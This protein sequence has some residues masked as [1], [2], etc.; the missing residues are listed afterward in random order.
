MNLRLLALPLLAVMTGCGGSDSSTAPGGPPVGV[1]SPTPS[2]TPTS[3]A[4]PNILLIVTDDLNT[5]VEGLDGHP[6]AYTP[7][8][9]RLAAR[10]VLFT[11]AQANGTVCSPSRASLLSG[12]LPSTTGKHFANLDFLDIPILS[13][14]KLLPEHFRDEGYAVYGT[15]KIFHERHNVV[16]GTEDRATHPRSRTDTSGGYLGPVDSYGPYPWDGI[17]KEVNWPSRTIP[18]GVAGRDWAPNSNDTVNLLAGGRW[19]NNPALPAAVQDWGFGFGRLSQPPVFRT[20]MNST[21]PAGWNYAGWSEYVRGPYSWGQG[22]RQPISD[23]QMTNWVVSLLRRQ[24]QADPRYINTAPISQRPFMIMMGLVGTHAPNYVPD[25]FFDKVITVNKINSID[26][27][28]LP[29]SLGG[30]LTGDGL[31][32]VPRGLYPYY[33]SRQFQTILTGG[34]EGG[35]I[36]DLVHPGQSITNTPARLIK[37]MILAYLA[38]VYEVDVQLGKILDALDADPSLAR[39]T[40]VVLTSDHGFHL[41]EKQSWEKG[42]LFNGT[43]RIPLIVADPRAE[44]DAGRGAKSSATVSLVDLYPTLVS[45]T[46]ISRVPIANSSPELDGVDFSAILRNS[47]APLSLTAAAL[48]SVYGKLD[49]TVNEPFAHNYSI[50]AGRWRYS[51]AVNGDEL[52]YDQTNDPW[53]YKN[54][55][56]D[57][58][59]QNVKAELKAQLRAIINR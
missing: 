54:L 58:N 18:F 25:E 39:N 9:K 56:R 5:Y 40:I 17:T 49:S 10:G 7:N 23:E 22:Q 47:E 36:P 52:L 4:R 37:S 16:F 20:G 50:R 55:A 19:N 53:E 51:L 43:T 31:S 32:E 48:S 29:P 8:M 42:T 27:V 21:Y 30:Q 26:D 24:A 14:A 3:A 15:G 38:S 41:G 34:M 13:R 1:G 33:H 46:K 35:S 11:Q 6:Q 44:F 57:P 2:P 28:E 12:Y 45:L 59:F